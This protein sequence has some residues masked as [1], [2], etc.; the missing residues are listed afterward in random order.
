MSESAKQKKSVWVKTGEHLF[1][2]C[3]L[4]WGM[5]WAPSTV[6]NSSLVEHGV[7]S[8]LSWLEP[9]PH[10][11]QTDASL[12][13][14][15]RLKGWANRVATVGEKTTYTL[16]KGATEVLARFMVW[17]TVFVGLL[18][19]ALFEVRQALARIFEGVL[20]F[21][22]NLLRRTRLDDQP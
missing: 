15:D 21:F 14:P 22:L 11:A 20:L 18:V 10:S 5:T 6:A 13:V 8:A 17:V 19:W 1:V 2:A 9:E 16:T 7:E 3:I 4:F 12:T